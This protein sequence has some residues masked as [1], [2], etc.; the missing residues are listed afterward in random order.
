MGFFADKTPTPGTR[1]ASALMSYARL[2]LRQRASKPRSPLAPGQ[3][4]YN[5]NWRVYVPKPWRPKP[6]GYV[7]RQR[8]WQLKQEAAGRC[9][10]C[11]QPNSSLNLL[12]PS[13]MDKKRAAAGH[14]PWRLGGPGRPP[15]KIPTL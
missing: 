7:S 11:G 13:C 6:D 3:R 10:L 9:I 8:R 4:R 15:K 5:G 2:F 12:C 14:Q 1:T